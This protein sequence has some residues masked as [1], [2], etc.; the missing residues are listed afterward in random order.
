MTPAPNPGLTWILYPTQSTFAENRMKNLLHYL[1]LIAIA[2]STVSASM[3]REPQLNGGDEVHTCDEIVPLVEISPGETK[4][5]V[6]ACSEPMI[7]RS[8]G[9]SLR[10][11]NRT[12][13]GIEFVPMKA[14]MNDVSISVPDMTAAVDAGDWSPKYKDLTS[15]SRYPFV[16]T[17]TASADAKPQVLELRV[18]NSRCGGVLATHFCVFVRKDEV[19]D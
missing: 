15:Q 12:S 13:K 1:I 10:K 7:S 4:E 8:S 3:P 17:I 11:I 18:E 16:V 19:A 9:L 2:I 5:L 6:L 14:D